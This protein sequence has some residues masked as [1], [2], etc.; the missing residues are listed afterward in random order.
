LPVTGHY[1]DETRAAIGDA[2]QK[3]I[4]NERANATAD[5]L[6]PNSRTIRAGMKLKSVAK[7]KALA[8]TFVMAGGASEQV[9]LLDTAQT[10]VDKMGQAKTLFETVHGWAAP[11]LGSPMVLVVGLVLVVAAYYVF[12]FANHVIDARVEDHRTEAHTGNDT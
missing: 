7:L 1:D 11:F 10:T 9:G 2:G 12:Q 3:T 8:G 6:A 5:D 4:S